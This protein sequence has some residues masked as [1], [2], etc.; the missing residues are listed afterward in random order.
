MQSCHSYFTWDAFM[1]IS[2][3]KLLWLIMAG[4]LLFAGCERKPRTGF[5]VTSWQMSSADRKV[6]G[7][8]DGSAYFGGY[9]EGF[10]I[11]IW[12]D[13]LA[14]S[15][16]IKPTWDKASKCAK[17]AGYVKSPSS[18]KINVECY[19][20]D[21][22]KGS[23]TIN[24]QEYDLANGSL[25]LLSFRS[26]QIRVGQINHDIYTITTKDIRQL[27]EDIPEIRAFY[28]TPAIK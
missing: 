3:A 21:R 16:P 19:V 28:E 18:P 7:I 14:C 8:G 26:P 6:H 15:F 12:T 1:K 10:A 9:G 23:I 2:P 4:I 22:M 17:Y 20:T 11:I 5:I 27:V 25:F 24:Q 13:I